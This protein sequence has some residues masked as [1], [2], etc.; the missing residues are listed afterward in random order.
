MVEITVADDGH[1]TGVL[2]QRWSNE[3]PENAH[4]EHI[5]TDDYS[6]YFKASVTNI[7]LGGDYGF[8]AVLCQP[9]RSELSSY[10]RT[11]RTR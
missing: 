9:G 6:L 3:N 11:R 10:I 1:P 7:R 2:I 8:G 4:R 5:G